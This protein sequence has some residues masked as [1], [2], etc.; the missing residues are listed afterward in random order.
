MQTNRRSFIRSVIAAVCLSCGWV[1]FA[2]IETETETVDGYTYSFRRNHFWKTVDIVNWNRQSNGY[3]PSMEPPRAVSPKPTGAL[4]IP[5]TL[6]GYA[7]VQIG[8]HAF[9]GCTELTS[10]VIPEGVRGILSSAFEGCENL[11]N[12]T[13]PPG[14]TDLQWQLFKGCAKL[15]SVTLPEGITEINGDTFKGCKSLTRVTI[16]SS[17]KTIWDSA[18]SGCSSLREVTIPEGVTSIRSFAFDGCSSLVNVTIPASVTSIDS[19]A[20]SGTTIR[21]NCNGLDG[22]YCIDGWLIGCNGDAIKNT[23]GQ[24]VLRDG[25]KGIVNDSLGW[26]RNATNI[27][28]IIPEGVQYI[29]DRAFSNW[30]GWQGLVSVTIPESV[31]RVGDKAFRDSLFWEKSPDDSIVYHDGWVMGIKGDKDKLVGQL[32]LRDGTRGIADNAFSHCNGLTDVRIPEGVRAIGDY[33]FTS[34]TNLTSVTLPSS[35]TSIGKEAFWDCCNL[36]NL[37]I[38]PNVTSIGFQAFLRCPLTDVVIPEGVTSIEAQT[39]WHCTDLKNVTIPS[40]VTSIGKEAF[41]SCYNLTSVTIP[42]SVTSIGEWAF[43]ACTSLTSVVISDGVTSIGNWAFCAC[44][45]LANI[46][47]P[48]SVTN[49]GKASFASTSLTSITIPSSVKRIGSEL[50][51]NTALL[52]EALFLGDAPNAD[53]IYSGASEELTTY[54]LPGST[55]WD[56]DLKSALLPDQWQGRNILHVSSDPLVAPGAPPDAADGWAEDFRAWLDTFYPG[57][58]G[59]YDALANTPG[60]NGIPLWDSYV[61]GLDPTDRTSRFKAFITM[62]RGAP[63]ITWDPRLRNR[64]YT[65]VG[66]ESLSGTADWGRTNSLTRFF[67]VRVELPEKF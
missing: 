13:I 14:V 26:G 39:F 42:P 31:T 33:T 46:T 41:L 52:R 25:I 55:G 37:T 22:F 18:F 43:G 56:G 1:G 65:V 49:I 64:T 48:S 44:R 47:I 40:S 36:T 11:E 66:K 7:V 51:Y 53:A 61:A 6:G 45:R 54:V 8:S 23:L 58:N 2:E 34:C 59:N 32:V 3:N 4:V 60:A 9:H 5:S 27:T 29:G 10:V 20:F 21:S 12:I 63:V 17:V 38:P 50:F 28:L 16:P 30:R 62:E 57:N 19:T 24:I 67:K 35:I 15:T